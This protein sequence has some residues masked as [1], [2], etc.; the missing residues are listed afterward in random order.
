MA[1]ISVPKPLAARGAIRL[2]DLA[3]KDEVQALNRGEAVITSQSTDR[4]GE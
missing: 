1:E 2:I 3:G 4:V